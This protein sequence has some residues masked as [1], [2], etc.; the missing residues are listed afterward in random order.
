MNTCKKCATEII[1]RLEPMANGS[2][3]VVPRI[4]IK[5]LI[6]ELKESKEVFYQQKLGFKTRL[7][8]AWKILWRT[9]F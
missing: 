1:D 2:G 8:L 3:L 7:K 6:E 4:A 5:A 9:K